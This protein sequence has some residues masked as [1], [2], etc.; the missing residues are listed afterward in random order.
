METVAGDIVK[1]KINVG[2]EPINFLTT[3]KKYSF[4][5]KTGDSRL[6]NEYFR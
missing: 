1:K 4:P 2:E 3:S 5:Y 6:P